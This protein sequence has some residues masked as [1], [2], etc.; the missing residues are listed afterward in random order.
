VHCVRVD[1]SG[2]KVIVRVLTARIRAAKVAAFNARFRQQVAMLREQPGLEYLRFARRFLPDGDEEA[3]L[4]EEW[5]DSASL[6]AWVG[7]DLAEPRLIDG[8]RELADELQV[9]HYEV[10][11]TGAEDPVGESG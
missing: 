2:G 11:A 3:I 8:A 10:L 7:P 1:V 5:A 9:V 6:Y 4:F